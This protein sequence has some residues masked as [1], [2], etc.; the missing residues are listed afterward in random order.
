MNQDNKCERVR[1][2]LMAALDGEAGADDVREHVASC[3]AC[4]SWRQELEAMD[5]RFHGVSYVRATEDLWPV[6]EPRLQ[7]NMPP[8]TMRHVWVVVVLVLGWRAVQLLIDVP[9][10]S[11]YLAA[12]VIVA[13]ALWHVCREA[14]TIEPY[15]PQLQK[16]GA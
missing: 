7:P 12:V 10:P 9:F 8:P 16:R 6:L 14:L 15:A 11:L 3:A 5:R 1:L 4:E 2:A 13:G